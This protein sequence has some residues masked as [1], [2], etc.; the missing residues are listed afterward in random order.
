MDTI[1]VKKKKKNTEE[2]RFVDLGSGKEMFGEGGALYVEGKN[3]S[4][5]VDYLNATERFCNETVK[6]KYEIE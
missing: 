2:Q 1:V 5:F 6:T 4:H 3:E